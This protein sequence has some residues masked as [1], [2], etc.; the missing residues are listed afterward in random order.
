MSFIDEHCIV[1]DSE[2]ENKLEY[3]QIHALFKKL[4]EGLLEELMA[5][6]GVT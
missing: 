4:V 6:L 2:E 3:T 5:E 1:F